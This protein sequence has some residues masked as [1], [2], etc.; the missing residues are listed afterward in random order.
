MYIVHYHRVLLMCLIQSTH[1]FTHQLHPLLLDLFCVV[2]SCCVVPKKLSCNIFND[3]NNNKNSNISYRFLL[4]G[5]GVSLYF[6]HRRWNLHRN[7]VF[8][9]TLVF[10]VLGGDSSAKVSRCGRC[11]R[12]RPATDTALVLLVTET[13]LQLTTKC[14]LSAN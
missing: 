9:F 8:H 6:I 5:Q 7:K 13:S 10:V 2:C 4:S 12:R 11:C 1:W 14:H 3:N